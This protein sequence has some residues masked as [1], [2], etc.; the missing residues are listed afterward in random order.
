[1]SR[2]ACLL[3]PDL[4]VAALCRTDPE[5]VHR[6]LVV[7]EGD[8]PHARI[9]AAAGPA[10]AR[11]VRPGVHSVAQARAIAAAL[12]V[13]PHDPPGERSPPPPPPPAPAPLPSPPAHTHTP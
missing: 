13:R 3:V 12:V 10:R 11:G 9:A 8:G 4:P 7:A 6:P 5:L 2:I 1:M